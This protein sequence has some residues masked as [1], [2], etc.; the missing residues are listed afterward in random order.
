M[1][2]LALVMCLLGGCTM[3]SDF[4]AY[5]FDK[6]IDTA[7][8]GG[9]GGVGGV[10]GM[11]GSGGAAGVGGTGAEDSGLAG[12]G[13]AAGMA[14]TG[15]EDSGAGSGGV[16]GSGGGEPDAGSDAGVEVPLAHQCEPTTSTSDVCPVGYVSRNSGDFKYGCMLEI[17]LSEECPTGF[18]LFKIQ[19]NETMA[20]CYPNDFRT[21]SSRPTCPEWLAIYGAQL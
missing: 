11:S 17:L 21:S 15:A 4:D 18:G 10:A 5:S 19:R 20:V 9:D 12:M 8:S 3:L 1:R 7:D 13:G 14:G 2:I 16:S 6:G